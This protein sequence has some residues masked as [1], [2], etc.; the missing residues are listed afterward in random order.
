[1]FVYDLARPVVSEEV[2]DHLV[3]PLHC[4]KELFL[5]GEELDLAMPLLQPLLLLLSLLLQLLQ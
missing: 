3:L 2:A 1:M 4:G 5:I